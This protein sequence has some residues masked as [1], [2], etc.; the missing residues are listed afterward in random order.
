MVYQFLSDCP[1]FFLNHP[2]TAT[3]CI[4]YEVDVVTLKIEH[5]EDLFLSSSQKQRVGEAVNIFSCCI[6]EESINCL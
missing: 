6:F 5:L 1:Q 3:D 4:G 2:G